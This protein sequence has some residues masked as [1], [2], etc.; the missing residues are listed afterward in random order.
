MAYSEGMGLEEEGW[1]K[2]SDGLVAVGL[3][4]GSILGSSVL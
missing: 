1:S 2:K 3:S 4:M